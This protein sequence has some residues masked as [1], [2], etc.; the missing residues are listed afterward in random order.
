MS[1]SDLKEKLARLDEERKAAQGELEA[2]RARRG[3]LEAL[4]RDAEALL[5][6]YVGKVPKELDRLWPEERQRF[7]KMMRLHVSAHTV[8]RTEVSGLVLQDGEDFCVEHTTS[9]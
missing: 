8:G 6:A 2:L 9:W 3:R 1:L 5:S 4:E 7:Y